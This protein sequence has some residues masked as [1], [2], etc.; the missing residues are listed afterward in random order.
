VNFNDIYKFDPQ[1]Y[2]NPNSPGY[3]PNGRETAAE[4]QVRMGNYWIPG[5][6]F[7]V[8]SVAAPI[9]QANS[10]PEAKW[11]GAGMPDHYVGLTY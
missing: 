5:K 3:D 8:S 2:N 10:D 1:P 11:I 9:S 6:P 7:D 4:W